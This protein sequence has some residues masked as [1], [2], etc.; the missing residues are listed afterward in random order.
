MGRGGGGLAPWGMPSQ[1]TRHIGP[2]LDQYWAD[3]VDGGP[4]LGKQWVY[5][6]CLLGSSLSLL[7]ISRYYFIISSSLS[8]FC[9]FNFNFEYCVWRAVSSHSFQHPQEVLLA[10]F[11]L[12]VHKGGLK[13]HSFHFCNFRTVSVPQ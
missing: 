11:S 13:P 2:M 1:Q 9:K 4:T 12:N 6:S 5:V 3:V 7:V 10:Q 8:M